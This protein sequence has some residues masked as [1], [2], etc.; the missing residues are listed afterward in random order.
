MIY[1]SLSGCPALFRGFRRSGE[2]ELRLIINDASTNPCRAVP[3]IP[4]R[5]V[6]IEIIHGWD[7]DSYK[8]DLARPSIDL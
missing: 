4:S 5:H 3:T 7:P 8:L 2:H 6:T 1:V